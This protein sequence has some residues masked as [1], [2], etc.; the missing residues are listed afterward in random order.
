M[1]SRSSSQ[2]SRR[3]DGT[4]EDANRPKEDFLATVSQELRTPLTAVLGWAH[5][6]R[7]GDVP[8]DRLRH[9]LKV[10]ERSARAQSRL[11]DDLL[12]V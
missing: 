12:D 9:G 11:I 7:A 1:I 3:R 2:R 4:Q 8:P 10:I 6:L 5:K